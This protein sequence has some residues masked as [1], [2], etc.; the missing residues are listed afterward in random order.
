MSLRHSVA[1]L[2]LRRVKWKIMLPFVILTAMFALF[3]TKNVT[4]LVTSSLQDRLEKQL[5]SASQYTADSIAKQER[6]QLELVRVVA[7]TQGVSEAV[8]TG[9]SSRLEAL[10]LPSAANVGAE[11][12]EIFGSS[13]LRVYGV[14]T[15]GASGQLTPI[16]NGIAPA[17]WTAISYVLEGKS[18]ERG[19]KWA[20]LA[21]T[22]EGPVLLT[23]G[24]IRDASGRVVGAAAVSSPLS[25]LLLAV[26]KN[27]FS[28][29][30]MFTPSGEALGS[31]FDLADASEANGQLRGTA[32]QSSQPGSGASGDV[33]GRGYQFLTNDLVVRGERI[34]TFSV[35]I[36]ADSVSNTEQATRLRMS[37]I[38]GAI[39]LG[40]IAVGWA[41]SRNLT[42]PLNRLVTAALA[43][44][45]GDLS[46]RSNVRT[47]DEIGL[48]GASFD[49]MAERLEE[50]HVATI[51]ALASAIDARDPYTAG[52]SVRVGD[53]SAELGTDLGMPRPAIH[54]LRVGGLLHDIGKIGV[55]DTILLKP[56]ALSPEER[57][58]IEQHPT[59]GLRILEGARLPGQVLEI[60]GGH[61][62]RLDGSGYPL[63]LS[64]EEISVFP[65]ITAVADMYDA[66]TTDRP[67][68]LG[69]SPQEAIRI[70][71]RD[72]ETGL[73]DPEV[74]AALR[75]IV[76]VWEERRAATVVQTTAWLESLQ[77]IK[78]FKPNAA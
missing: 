75:R 22:P 45:R 78:G 69:L 71:W 14:R 30:T 33:L 19:D 73:V 57:R 25:S 2:R 67:Y 37:L 44:S 23:V 43:V 77:A 3:A 39:T 31:T 16:A 74:V 52:H 13:G 65:R 61:H 26:K 41:V 40:V 34:G 66:L 70:L 49:S 54:H 5:V 64:A 46:A 32:D 36:P 20:Q 55:R 28:D 1:F 15:D 63:G 21:N 58:L 9:N 29:V 42:S 27:A 72:A 60:V 11:R 35:A 62:E 51:G 47:G 68:R 50:Q 8:A 76:R 38:F 53:L 4:E 12:V 18:D 56:G 6:D 17:E 48:L 24:P 59:I 10:V 7:F